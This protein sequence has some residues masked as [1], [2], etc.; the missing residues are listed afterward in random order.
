MKKISSL[1]TFVVVF[2]AIFVSSRLHAQQSVYVIANINS[3]AYTPIQAYS[4][5][6][7]SLVF[8][9][10]Y[11]V[12]IFG[13]GAVGLCIDPVSAFL[14]VTYEDSNII[15]LLN[16]TTMTSEGTTTA[17]SAL[18][19]AGIVYDKNNKH[20]YA[21]D[22]ETNK[23]Y[24]YIWNASNHEL[25][26]DYQ[27]FLEDAAAY[28]I[29]LDVKN[30]L[31]YVANGYSITYYNT[32]D[33]SLAGTIDDFINPGVI[34][35][36]KD[37]EN[38]LLYYGGYF[39]ENFYLTKYNLETGEQT[40]VYLNEDE[41]V[42][43]MTINQNTG[44]LYITVGQSGDRI[45]AFDQN[46][47]LV[48][49][50]DDI[51]DPTDIVTSGVAYNPLNFI[52]DDGFDCIVPGD[53]IELSLCFEN[54]H[55]DTAINV[56]ITSEIPP[57]TTYLSSSTGGIYD[58]T[59]NIVVWDLGD[60]PGNTPQT[61]VTLELLT[62]N[63]FPVSSYTVFTSSIDASTIGIM[64]V[65]EFEMTDTLV[66]CELPLANLEGST[67]ICKGDTTTLVIVFSG[68]S[69]WEVVYTFG[70]ETDTISDISSKKYY[71]T[72]SPDVT[73]TYE[74]LSVSGGNGMTNTSYGSAT[75]TVNPIPEVSIG[76]D[77]ILMFR[78]KSTTLSPGPDFQEYLWQDGSALPYY[79]TS[80]SGTF[81]VEVTDTNNCKNSDTTH[82]LLIDMYI[83]NAFTPNNDNNNDKVFVRGD[84]FA[85]IDFKIFNRLGELVFH[86][87][88]QNIGWDG[89]FKGHDQD[90][91]V[92]YYYFSGTLIDGREVEQTG[93]ITLIR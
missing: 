65:G 62:S 85:K 70:S 27:V 23:L 55:K 59:E 87:T 9:A 6:G 88:D 74:L 30:D 67:S 66:A 92:Y 82:V 39:A 57:K 48:Y 83:P 91:G 68:E 5:E 11:G 24:S 53:T 29:F 32:N 20:V 1:L 17:P 50:S 54:G 22:R 69:P 34:N 7:D 25:T 72:V 63:D 40:G 90:M 31:L 46:L 42:M 47:N 44:L 18:D 13:E 8:Q 58:P 78:G 36:E 89:T 49:E 64:E 2:C 75:V 52:I 93:N 79:T 71:L 26:L 45:K 16:A 12:Q 3:S 35:V 10:Q 28:G 41:G 77:T 19:L 21:M 38:N 61:C 37:I 4:I 76:K 15:Q 56:V 80:D 14:F 33:W 84:F 43:G 86:T 51:G 60:I 73:T 81:W